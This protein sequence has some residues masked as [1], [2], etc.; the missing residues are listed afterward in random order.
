MFKMKRMSMVLWIAITFLPLSGCHKLEGEFVN[1]KEGLSLKVVSID[2]NQIKVQL[3][4]RGVGGGPFGGVYDAYDVCSDRLFPITAKFDDHVAEVTLERFKEDPS[5]DIVLA[6]RRGSPGGDNQRL[7]EIEID[8]EDSRIVY[9]Y[10]AN[11]SCQGEGYM[12]WIAPFVGKLQFIKNA[13]E[14]RPD[15]NSLKFGYPKGRLTRD[16]VVKGKILIV[17][18]DQSNVSEVIANVPENIL[19]TS[20]EELNTLV[21]VDYEYHQ[22]SKQVRPLNLTSG[23]KNK[24]ISNWTD[25]YLHFFQLKDGLFEYLFSTDILTDET[26]IQEKKFCDPPVAQAGKV[27]TEMVQ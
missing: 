16:E 2:E 19:A 26:L 8:L 13:C 24:V 17:G 20:W 4:N 5:C 6:V 27:M 7:T 9:V 23:Y 14:K 3:H 10:F 12:K 22:E 15:I 18:S 1:D 11:I 25:I 21:F